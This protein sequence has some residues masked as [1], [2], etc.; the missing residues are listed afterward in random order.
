MHRKTFE[1]VQTLFGC[2]RFGE[3]GKYGKRFLGVGCGHEPIVY[4]LSNHSQEM[5]ATDLYE[6]DWTGKDGDPAVSEN[7]SSY[8]PF[9]FN[10]E[11]LKF[12]RR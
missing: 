7:E 1:W 8:A 12:F 10:P 2:S 3:A 6:G 5:V 11:K 9:E 4:W